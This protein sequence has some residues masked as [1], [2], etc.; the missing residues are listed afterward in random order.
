MQNKITILTFDLDWCEDKVF[1][2][3]L[4][5]LIKYKVPATFFVTHASKLLDKIRKYSFFELGIHPNLNKD[6]THGINYQE[7]I[8]HCLSIVPEAISFRPHGLNISSNI[9][10]Y[11]M[12]RGIKIDCSIFM[13]NTNDINQY[14]FQINEKKILRVP[15][16]WSDDYEFYQ[17]NKKYKFDDINNYKTL[18]MDFH[19][20]HVYLNSN[21]EHE[22]EK[23]KSKKDFSISERKGSKNML[24]E[25]IDRYA[26]GDIKIMNL[27]DYIFQKK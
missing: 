26:K 8:D 10:I 20:I 16:N 19:P 22:Y 5:K 12:N 17:K 6:S 14:Y 18:I 15:F 1:N 13:P 23:Y 2:Y 9:L 3:T 27:K 25:V 4:D 7:A 24:D 21:S 11:L